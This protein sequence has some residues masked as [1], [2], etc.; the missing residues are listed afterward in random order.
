MNHKIFVGPHFHFYVSHNS[1]KIFLKKKV[2]QSN[3][4][5][6]TVTRFYLTD[7][8]CIPSSFYTNSCTCCFKCDKFLLPRPFFMKWFAIFIVIHCKLYNVL[9]GV[10]KQVYYS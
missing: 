8:I 1:G 2:Q 7:E 4:E 10:S 3:V 5:K 6:I 9:E